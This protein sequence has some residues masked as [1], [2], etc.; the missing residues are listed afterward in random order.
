VDSS[1]NCENIFKATAKDL[2]G[3]GF[4]TCSNAGQGSEKKKKYQLK[5]QLKK[6]DV[7]ILEVQKKFESR[8][9]ESKVY[10]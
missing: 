5:W 7:K 8:S 6:R 10:A 9:P 2:L 4:G 3:A 1:D